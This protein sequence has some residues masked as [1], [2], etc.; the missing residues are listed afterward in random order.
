MSYSP[1]L[2]SAFNNTKLR[3]EKHVTDISGMCSMCSSDCIGSCEIGISA[4]R[5]ADAVYPTTT[6]EN[7][8]ASEKTYPIDYSHFNINGRAFGAFGAKEDF[9]QTTIN[10]VILEKTI[11][12]RNPIK[13]KLPIILPALAKLNWQDYFSG[14]AMAGVISFIG[15]GA[16]EKDPDFTLENGKLIYCPKLNDFLDAFRKY[17]RGYGQIVLQVNVDDD[18]MGVP[19]YAIEKCGCEAIEFKFGQSAKGIQ[20]VNKLTSLESAL[21]EYEKGNIVIPDPSD[22]KVQKR[23]KEGKGDTFRLYSRLCMWKEDY[24]LERIE[25][26]RKKGLK[27]VYFKMAGYDP[28]DIEKVL[29]IAAKADVDMITFDGAGGGSG[30][31]PCRMMNEWGLPAC[32]I[33][34]Y[35]N[36]IGKR[37]EEE[38]ITLPDIAV[39]G[40]FTMEDQVYKALALGA[41]YTS[42]VGICRGSMA[43]AMSG[44]NIGK[45]L[46]EK[47][48]PKV[49]RKFGETKEE[50]FPELRE[51]RN[52]YGEKA[53]SFSEGAIGVYSYL[54]R[55]GF[56]L[57]HFAAL[58][59]KFNIKY[60]NKRDI[61]PM[62]YAAKELLEGHWRK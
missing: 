6:G 36:E 59:R 50:L 45:L 35:I 28:E 29:R 18:R 9:N 20:P 40:G 46:K 48:I 12:K 23:Y 19:D 38:R 54:K 37:L 8:I 33:Q 2:C 57:K 16:A 55:I 1:N 22:K 61:I 43:A 25:E 11:G 26:L 41:P 7:Q 60:I 51:L 47:K 58:N 31:S 44:N 4:L 14:A 39:T 52:I 53:D 21:K 30:Y 15:E 32:I 49:L 27:N 56:G 17:Y 5:G 24:L 62:T 42:A 34:C 13:I 10:D 3:D